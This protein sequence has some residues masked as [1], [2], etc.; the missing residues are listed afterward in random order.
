MAA[1][2]TFGLDLVS[3]F[4]PGDG[5]LEGV[6]VE[7][8]DGGETMQHEIDHSYNPLTRRYKLTSLREMIDKVLVRLH[9]VKRVCGLMSH[10]Y[11]EP[12]EAYTRD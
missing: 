3:V 9:N 1:T 7:D 6:S 10:E 12:L 2:C 11:K 4:S 5:E 8:S